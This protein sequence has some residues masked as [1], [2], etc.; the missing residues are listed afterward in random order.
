MISGLPNREKMA[1]K[2]AQA[3]LDQTYKN[4]KLIV[5]NNGDYRI[6]DSISSELIEEI[7]PGKEKTLGELRNVSLE[8]VPNGEIWIQWDDDDWR[9]PE[10]CE[11]MMNIITSKKLDMLALRKQIQYCFHK[12]NGYVVVRDSGIEGSVAGIKCDIRYKSLSKGEDTY[13]YNE[14]K[15]KRKTLVWDNPSTLYLRFIHNNNTWDMA[16]FKANRI[17]K[18]K[19]QMSKQEKEFLIS[20]TKIY[21]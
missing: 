4:K 18:N 7:N 15:K 12:N 21:A 11:K 16:H 6:K 17:A 20:I 5:I 14:Y 2:A 8:Q 9:H 3:F 1:V 19:F 10:T 13:F